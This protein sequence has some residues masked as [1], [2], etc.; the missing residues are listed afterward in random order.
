MSDGRREVRSKWGGPALLPLALS[1]LLAIFAAALL[2]LVMIGSGIDDRQ[3]AQADPV[4]DQDTQQP[5]QELAAATPPPEPTP[6]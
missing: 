1:G 3:I 2:S 5:A 6:P 4:V